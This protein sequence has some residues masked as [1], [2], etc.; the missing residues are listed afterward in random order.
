MDLPIYIDNGATFPIVVNITAGSIF[1]S[2]PWGETQSAGNG[3]V[4]TFPTNDVF[5]TGT[6]LVY[7]SGVYQGPG[8]DYVEATNGASITFNIAVPNTFP[9]DIRYVK[10]S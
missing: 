5:Q 2:P 10:A 7:V 9:V 4:T 8:V 6:T 1:V 3:V